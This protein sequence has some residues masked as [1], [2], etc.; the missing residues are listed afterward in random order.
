M[1]PRLAPFR[2]FGLQTRIMLYVTIGLAVMF[3]GFTYVGFLSLRQATE[4]VYLERLSAAY[5][6][7]GVLQRDFLHVARDMDEISADLF[8]GDAEHLK[9]TAQGLLSHL[10]GTDPFPFFRVTGIWVLSGEGVIWAVAG[11]P[12]VSSSEQVGRIASSASRLGNSQFVVIPAVGATPGAVSFGTIIAEVADP[13]DSDVML[14]AAHI[15]SINSVA[16]YVPATYWRIEPNTT[17]TAAGKIDSQA[18]YHVEVVDANGFTVLGIGG[19]ESPGKTSSHFPAIRSLVERGQAGT[20]LHKPS[21]AD[22]F[23]PHVMSVVPLGSSPFY[24]IQEQSADVA[25]ALPIELRSRVLLVALFGFAAAL[26]IAWIT[27]RQVVKPIERLTAAA[28]Y[29]SMGDLDSPIKVPA[30]D[31]VER[32]AESLESMRQQLRDAYQ[33]ISRANE[34]LESRINERTTRL[35]EVLGRVISAQEEERRRL[36]RELHDETAQTIGALSIALDRARLDLQGAS[37]DAVERI[38]EAQNAVRRLLDEIRRLILDLRPIALE[39]LGLV[40]AIRWYAESHLQ[41]RGIQTAIETHQLAARL[42]EHLEISLFRIVQE[43]INNIARHARAQQASIRLLLQNSVARIE[44]TDDGQGFNV[45][46]V[47]KPHLSGRGVGL[48]GMQERA[49]L[50]GGRFNIRSEPGKGTHVTV[51]VPIPM[52]EEKR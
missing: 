10:S 25:L 27:T 16:P 51:E 36:A 21:P 31:E 34:E 28:Q 47:L 29:M 1:V 52:A 15:A 48:M 45:E 4:Q 26:S 13:L 37:P 19:E 32:L 50:L 35:T 5:T 8:T 18:A 17:A 11:E 40:P 20:M 38:Q 22:V 23:K 42:P 43:A 44:V 2:R 41:E 3:G 6:T 30:Q 39:D 12:G 14:I 9:T 33:K 7:A 49:R 24:V 46:D